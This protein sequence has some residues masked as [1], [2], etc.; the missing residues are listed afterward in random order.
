MSSYQYSKMVIKNWAYGFSLVLAASAVSPSDRSS[1]SLATT[2]LA[3]TTTNPYATY[4]SVAHTASINGFADRIYGQLPQCAK[5]CVTRSTSS[6]PCPYWDTGCLCVMTPWANPVANCIA[7]LCRGFDVVSATSLAISLCSSA[8]VWE[9]YW[10]IDESISTSLSIAAADAHATSSLDTYLSPIAMT[11]SPL[12]SM[13]TLFNDPQTEQSISSGALSTAPSDMASTSIQLSESAIPIDISSEGS[14]LSSASFKTHDT[15]STL[16]TERSGSL[17]LKSDSSSASSAQRTVSTTKSNG[18]LRASNPAS[19]TGNESL[20]V[21]SDRSFDTWSTFNYSAP[22][23]LE[24]LGLV[25]FLR[26][27]SSI[28]SWLQKSDTPSSLVYP[29]ITSQERPSTGAMTITACSSDKCSTTTPEVEMPDTTEIISTEVITVTLC[30][31]SKCVTHTTIAEGG[32]EELNEITKSV[33]EGSQLTDI[34]TSCSEEKCSVVWT[35][36]N[37]TEGVIT[38]TKCSADMCLFYTAT[39]R[40]VI[41]EVNG[42]NSAYITTYTEK[43]TIG[44]AMVTSVLVSRTTAETLTSEI[45]TSTSVTITNASSTIEITCLTMLLLLLPLL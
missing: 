44:D 28:E 1:T 6:T 39:A 45:T 19:I 2:S 40:L 35:P 30:S 43:A 9:P 27:S 3:I 12:T 38:L 32:V 37:T 33:S 15:S 16:G 31:Q 22:T 8:G 36:T 20:N 41:T 14:N 29:S 4:P 42:T 13:P 11:S 18:D 34:V 25:S 10:I 17:S 7:E 5:S 23:S 26:G 21:N 24:S